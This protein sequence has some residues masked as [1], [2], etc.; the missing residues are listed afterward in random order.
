VDGGGVPPGGS[1]ADDLPVLARCRALTNR[2]FSELVENIG[3]AAR[4]LRLTRACLSNAID[5]G[6]AQATATAVRVHC[7]NM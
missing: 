5:S 4:Q 7:Y 6:N 2:E 1:D 3:D